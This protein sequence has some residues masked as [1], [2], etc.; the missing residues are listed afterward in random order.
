M[1]Q[2]QLRRVTALLATGALLLGLPVAA[3]EPGGG[4]GGSPPTDAPQVRL[5]AATCGSFSPSDVLRGRAGRNG[6]T[7]RPVGLD[8]EIVHNPVN[9]ADRRDRRDFGD[10]R[11][12]GQRRHNGTDYRTRCRTPVRAAHSG[13]AI[14]LPT[15]GRGS[16][17]GVSTGPRR[18]TT[19]YSPVKQVRVRN[20]ALVAGGR[21]LGTVARSRRHSPCRLHFS[22]HLRAGARDPGT[23]DPSRWLR[24]NRKQHV[25]GLPPGQPRKGTFVVATLNVLGHSHTARGG[26]KR[27][28]YAGSER[29]MGHAVSLLARNYVDIVGLQE[30]QRVQRRSFLRRTKH[31]R[32]F[33]PR[34]PQDSIAWRPWRFRLLRSSTLSVPYF[35]KDRPMPVVVLRDKATGQRLVVISVHNPAGRDMRKRRARA[36]ARELRMVETMRRRTRAP[37]ILLGDFNDK[38]RQFYCRVTRN[39]LTASSR[40]VPGRRCRP[41]AVAGID[42]ILG[43]NR[44]RFLAHQRVQGG[45]VARATDHPFVLARARL[46]R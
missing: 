32:I 5:V 17:V 12:H 6:P 3:S 46:R 30:L 16:T 8:G 29:R 27:D 44:V 35:R 4:R 15:R 33:S 2:P 1:A 25:T 43:T 19:W 26:D 14:V 37:V 23:V 45:L 9:R 34:D 36:L 11:V 10:R 13:K 22:V 40:G 31:W 42:W 28:R 20:G 7:C 18:L 38:S 39:G 24:R 21:R 41:S